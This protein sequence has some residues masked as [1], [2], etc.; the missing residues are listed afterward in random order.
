M[1][2]YNIR[3]KR[4]Y[5]MASDEDLIRLIPAVGANAP[6]VR[7]SILEILAFGLAT[8]SFIHVSGPSGMGKTL[9]LDNFQRQDE[10]WK[11][12]LQ[13]IK[14]PYKPLIIKSIEMCLF[15]SP[16]ELWYRRS[17]RVKNGATETWD[18][19]SAIVQ[20]LKEAATNNDTYYTIWL[21]EFGRVTNPLI[22]T[23]LLD[24][25]TKSEIQIDSETRIPP[26][27]VSWIADSNFQAANSGGGNYVLSPMCEAI[28]RR[29]EVQVEMPYL[30]KDQEMEIVRYLVKE[31]LPSEEIDDALIGNIVELGSKIRSL[32]NSGKISSVNPTP[33]N[34]LAAYRLIKGLPERNIITILKNTL[35]GNPS[36][37]DKA[38]IDSLINNVF[39]SFN[40]SRNKK[41]Y[42]TQYT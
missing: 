37:Q 30:P 21:R 5:E 39:F 15:D 19:P 41:V 3:N 27:S 38:Q 2:I 4:E 29:F 17:L 40:F 20:A 13:K 22:S 34:Y 26:N 11:I 23:A 42:H 18:E 14:L 8:N 12:L 10:N 31:N 36:D 28:N 35:V 16:S 24:L 7:R 6:V 9:L 1:A 25:M 32:R 33:Y